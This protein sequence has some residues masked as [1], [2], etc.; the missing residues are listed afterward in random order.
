MNKKLYLGAT[1]VALLMLGVA[2]YALYNA[3]ANPSEPENVSPSATQGNNTAQ[4][5]TP[6]TGQTITVTGTVVCLTPKK[7]DGPQV[8]SCAIGLKQDDGKS[9]ALTSQD[10][11]VVGSLPGGSKVTVT[12]SLAQPSQQPSEF[13]IVG[14]IAVTTVQRL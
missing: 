11:T 5:P 9:Y 13:D 1:I 3:S 4:N 8:T 6:A 10:P 7:T 12:G 2:A 14:V